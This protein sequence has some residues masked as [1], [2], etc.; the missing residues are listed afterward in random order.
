MGTD[1]I[2]LKL[3]FNQENNNSYGE[4]CRWLKQMWAAD[5]NMISTNNGHT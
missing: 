3:K 4:K 1:K 2:F 5:E